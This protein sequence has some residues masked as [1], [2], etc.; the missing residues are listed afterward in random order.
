MNIIYFFIFS[1][2]SLLYGNIFIHRYCPNMIVIDTPGLIHP[3]KGKQLTPQQRALVQASKEAEELVL[4]KIKYDDYII[5]CV[6]DT[7][8]W[9]HATTRN[10]VTRADPLLTRTVLVT[11]KYDTKLPQFSE[12]SDLY[13]FLNASII[14]TQFNQLLGGP[15]YTS[16]PSGRVGLTKDFHSNNE[17]IHEL[18]KIESLDYYTTMNKLKSSP[19]TTTTTASNIQNNIG[20]TNLRLFLESKI[21]ESYRYNV[22]K[23]LPLLDSEMK[24]IDSKLNEVDV[25]LST[26]SKDYIRRN[27]NEYRERI[28]K[29]VSD[30]IEGK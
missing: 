12:S 6:E 17:Y 29:T 26:L 9:K 5:L 8:D 20:I 22:N 30:L 4:N 1:Y 16:V 2:F 15:Y 23:I 24:R 25:A 13:D 7:T 21:E 28:G 11:T 19:L 3:P 18:N 14:K 27:I 10:L